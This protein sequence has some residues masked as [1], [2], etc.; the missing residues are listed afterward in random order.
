MNINDEAKGKL[1]HFNHML[2][3]LAFGYDDEG[4]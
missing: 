2:Y 4:R 3:M 1:N